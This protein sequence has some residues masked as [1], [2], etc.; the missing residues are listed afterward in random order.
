MTLIEVMVAIVILTVAVYLLSTTVTAAIGHNSITRERGM[1]VDGAMN[2]IEAMHAVPFDELYARFNLNPDDDPLGP[3]TAL[4]AD[5]DVPGLSP[6]PGDPDGKVGRVIFPEAIVEVVEEEEGGKGGGKA[7]GMEGGGEKSFAY[8]L[9]EDTVASELSMPRDLN[10]D[11][12]IDK[13][14]HADDYIVLPVL[15]RIEWQGRSGER[16]LEFSTMFADL[17]KDE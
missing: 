14:D 3:G 16:K 8:Q 12:V 10:G 17:E 15:V 4:G 7:G 5:F 1:A 11:L 13:L 6:I 2:R 9:R